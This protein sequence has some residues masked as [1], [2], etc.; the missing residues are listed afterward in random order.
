MERLDQET[1]RGWLGVSRVYLL[2]GG[3]KAWEGTEYPTVSKEL[4]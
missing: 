1:L 4:D 3:R 2:A